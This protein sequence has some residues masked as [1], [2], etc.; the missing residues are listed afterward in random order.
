MMK[1]PRA[2]ISFQFLQRP[3]SPGCVRYLGKAFPVDACTFIETQ[4]LHHRASFFLRSMAGT[5]KEGLTCLRATTIRFPFRHVHVFRV[6]TPPHGTPPTHRQPPDGGKFETSSKSDYWATLCWQAGFFSRLDN[7]TPPFAVGAPRIIL[8][9]P[10][11]P[12][13]VWP[14]GDSFMGWRQ[15]SSLS[16]FRLR[17]RQSLCA[18]VS[19]EAIRAFHGVAVGMLVDPACGDHLFSLPSNSTSKKF[20]GAA[21]KARFRLCRADAGAPTRRLTLSSLARLRPQA[22]AFFALQPVR[23]ISSSTRH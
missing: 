14:A 2:R 1:L 16:L 12:G 18:F 22:A 6:C 17:A 8:F 23:P 9:P 4:C 21:A 19:S 5:P 20:T 13:P 11:D 7:A 10:S 3:F 15:F